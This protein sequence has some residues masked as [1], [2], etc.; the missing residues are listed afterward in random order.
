MEERQRKGYNNVDNN[1]SICDVD[2]GFFLNGKQ[3]NLFDQGKKLQTSNVAT[4]L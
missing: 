1:N 3:F 4:R 2:Y